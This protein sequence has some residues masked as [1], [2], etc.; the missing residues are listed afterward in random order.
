VAA[1][2]PAAYAPASQG[3]SE[4]GRERPLEE[5]IKELLHGAE[6]RERRARRSAKPKSKEFWISGFV[7]GQSRGGIH[8]H[9]TVSRR[10]YSLVACGCH[11]HTVFSKVVRIEPWFCA[12]AMT[13]DTNRIQSAAGR[14]SGGSEVRVQLGSG[15][16]ACAR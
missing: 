8:A 6:A 14:L 4:I 9:S 13:R 16:C 15:S 7:D 12:I 11:R 5:K 2:T 10:D 1:N 3:E